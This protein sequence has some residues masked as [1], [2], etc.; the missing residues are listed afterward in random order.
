MPR[1]RRELPREQCTQD[2]PWTRSHAIGT[3]ARAHD[4]MEAWQ[5]SPHPGEAGRH[6]RG[7]RGSARGGVGT[8]ARQGCGGGNRARSGA[9]GAGGRQCV[10]IPGLSP[11]STGHPQTRAHGTR[12]RHIPKESARRACARPQ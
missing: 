3:R 5:V 6:R 10:G 9:Q 2:P 8:G 11:L 4:M 7:E 12:T 1:S